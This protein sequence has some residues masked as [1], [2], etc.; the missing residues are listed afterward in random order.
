MIKRKSLMI[1]CR[2]VFFPKNL[3]GK[4]QTDPTP[5]EAP[6]IKSNLDRISCQVPQWI[7][8]SRG[9]RWKDSE[10]SAFFCGFSKENPIAPSLPL[11]V[12][13]KGFAAKKRFASEEVNGEI[14]IIEKFELRGVS[15]KIFTTRKSGRFFQLFGVLVMETKLRN[16]SFFPAPMREGWV[17][18]LH[19]AAA[20]LEQLFDFKMLM[21]QIAFFFGGWVGSSSIKKGIEL[22]TERWKGGILEV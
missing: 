19:F 15:N 10:L 5:R 14:C 6:R 21:G 22:R 12:C 1:F 9:V 13:S 11:G 17:W 20:L 7:K 2:G 16:G 3:G 18:K 4:A 8:K